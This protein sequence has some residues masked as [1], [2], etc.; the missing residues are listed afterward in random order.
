[1]ETHVVL[2]MININ[3]YLNLSFSLKT[4]NLSRPNIKAFEFLFVKYSRST[5][6]YWQNRNLFNQTIACKGKK[7]SSV[8][9]F[10][11]YCNPDD[12]QKS[13]KRK[14]K[15]FKVSDRHKFV[16]LANQSIYIHFIHIFCRLILNIGKQTSK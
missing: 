10:G 5:F 15:K 1:M 13:K 16:D 11:L 4:F 8:L 14:K 2:S 3:F 6:N 9:L 7:D 12:R